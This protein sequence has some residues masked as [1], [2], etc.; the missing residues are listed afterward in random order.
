MT[1]MKRKPGPGKPEVGWWGGGAAAAGET[2]RS[3]RL[4]TRAKG[5]RITGTNQ[6][7]PNIST[8]KAAAHRLDESVDLCIFIELF[9]HL[10]ICLL[11][12]A[13]NNKEL[14]FNAKPRNTSKIAV[15]CCRR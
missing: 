4:K 12:K 3:E 11:S 5:E 1:E 6:E 7:E 8:V 2:E 9:Q 10:N 14:F 15:K 13:S